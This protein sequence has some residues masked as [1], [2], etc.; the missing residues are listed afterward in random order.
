MTKQKFTIK[1]RKMQR[2]S[3]PH[4]ELPP[5]IKNTYF[6]LSFCTKRPCIVM[7]CVCG[8]GSITQLSL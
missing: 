6:Q 5:N 4:G 8:I 2:G 1:D 7:I 3:F